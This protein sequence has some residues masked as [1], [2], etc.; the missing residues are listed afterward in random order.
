MK[1]NKGVAYTKRNTGDDLDKD[2]KYEYVFKHYDLYVNG[3]YIA[4][5]NSHQWITNEG[6][7][8]RKGSKQLGSKIKNTFTIKSID[9]DK[10]IVVMGGTQTCTSAF[11][12][13]DKTYEYVVKVND[14]QLARME[15][16]MSKNKDVTLTLQKVWT[17]TSDN[18]A[19]TYRITR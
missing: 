9:K 18:L 5:S 10:K 14:S 1:L 11:I 8:I 3:T 12:K 19:L 16:A 6:E 15:D 7:K 2:V 4:R 13:Y 17:K